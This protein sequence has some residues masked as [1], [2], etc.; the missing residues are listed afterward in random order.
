MP[1]HKARKFS[2]VIGTTSFLNCNNGNTKIKQL[3]NIQYLL[4][5]YININNKNVNILIFTLICI[6][7]QH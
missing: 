4:I 1:V 6:H 5:D 7:K 2:A 3:H